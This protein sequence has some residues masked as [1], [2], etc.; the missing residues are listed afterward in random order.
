MGT[1]YGAWGNDSGEWDLDIELKLKEQ[2]GVFDGDTSTFYMC[3]ED[4]MF[5]FNT[6]HVC[7]FQLATWNQITI[8]GAWYDTTSGGPPPTSDEDA[9]NWLLNPR[10]LLTVDP[11]R[12]PKDPDGGQKKRDSKCSITMSLLND[13]A[14]C[15]R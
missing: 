15:Y 7:H 13:Q 5:I 2:L 6:I 8:S 14:G 3:V 1:R 4:F 9:T 10:Y 12:E 11:A